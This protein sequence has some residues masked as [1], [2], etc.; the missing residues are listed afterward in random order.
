[1]INNSIIVIGI[2]CNYAKEIISKYNHVGKKGIEN[3][4]NKTLRK[5]GEKGSIPVYALHF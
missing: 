5:R 1:M 4:K 2:S 3:L